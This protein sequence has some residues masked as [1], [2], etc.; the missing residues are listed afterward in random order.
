MNPDLLLDI[1][2]GPEILSRINILKI[3]MEGAGVQ[4]LFLTHK[5]DIYYFSGTAQDCYLYVC[6]D[7]DP[8]LFVKRY[9]PRAGLET[10]IKDIIPVLSIKDIPNGIMDAHQR[11]PSTMGLALDVV[12]VRDYQFFQGLFKDTTFVDGTPLIEACR[13][14]KSV[15]EIQ[16]MEAVAKVSRKSFDFMEK[17][18]TPGISEM[19]F[20]GSIEAFARTQGHSGKLQMR[21]YRSEGFSFHLMSGKTGGLAGA[22]DSPVCGTGTCTA[23]PFGAGPKLIR[24]NEPILIDLGTMVN[25]YHMDESRMFVLGKMEPDAMAA[26][27]AALE[28]LN[29]IQ[30]ALKPDVAIG[31]I[32]DTSVRAAVKMG[33]EQEYLGLPKLKSRFVGH[34]I[35]LEL[36]ENPVLARGRSTRLEPGMVFAVEPKFIFKDRF[37]AGIESVIQITDTGS[38]FLSQTENKVFFC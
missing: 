33:Y 4:A 26:S 29:L 24:E 28:I 7:R 5:P 2:P 15:Y 11:L 38:R 13:R 9:L 35:G 14:I 32:F 17:N 3:H 36:V 31:E 25:G 23:Y 8:L 18:L 27:L 34:G 20:C 19:E 6:L 30:E 37:A 12:P 22:L 1:T 21:H 10:P 16:Q